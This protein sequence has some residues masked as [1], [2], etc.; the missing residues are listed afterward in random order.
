M[1]TTLA[2]KDKVWRKL[3]YNLTKNK[4]QA[5]DLVQDMY[6]KLANETKQLNDYYVY[7]TIKHLFYHS[8]RGINTIS[9]E[10]IQHLQIDE[11]TITEER[12]FID[13]QLNKLPL[14]KREILLLTHEKSL[15][16]CE[17][18]V[19]ISY[20]V[21]NYH[22]NKI[23]PEFKNIVDEATERQKNKRI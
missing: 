14:F 6:L 9:I 1:L 17:K 11:T 4:Q 12:I 19:G 18:E 22:K 23:L 7:L 13:K 15:R 20:G 21:F 2:K 8:K 16:D 5:D 10:D 3:A